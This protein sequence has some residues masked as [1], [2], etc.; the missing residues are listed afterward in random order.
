MTAR[1]FLWK[2]LTSSA[3]LLALVGGA[4]NPRI[5]AKKS[6]TS[7]REEHPFI[8]YKLGNETNEEL[9]EES[10][11]SRQYLQIWVHDYSDQQVSDY[12]RIDRVL[13]EIRRTLKNAGSGKDGVWTTLY[14]E[15]SQD[16]NDDTLNTVF[17]YAR[18]LVIKE[19]K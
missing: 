3:P 5:F 1:T 10:D 9:S 11:I 18:F 15:T 19:E 7:S 2:R 13:T 8:V 14:I 16:L 12:A 6:M 17:R 4:T